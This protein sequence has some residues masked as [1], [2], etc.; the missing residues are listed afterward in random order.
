MPPKKETQT[1]V[2]D[3]ET[4]NSFISSTNHRLVVVDVFSSWCGP[5]EVMIPTFKNINLQLDESDARIQF[6]A[7]DADKVPA[8]K[9]HAGTSKPRFVFYKAG[10]V[11]G[12]I[13]GA[14]APAI[15]KFIMENVPAVNVDKE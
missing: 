6:L 10:K 12:E 2:S 8:V 4:W 14:N 7:A 11:V 5:C 15:V 3:V 1:F 13:H 9:Q